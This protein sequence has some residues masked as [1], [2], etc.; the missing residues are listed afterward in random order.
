MG[1]LRV[2]GHGIDLGDA[3]RGRVEERMAGTIA[4]YLDTHM[5]DT[6]S[7]HVTLRRDGTAY[8]TD[9]VLHLVS[10]LTI[11]ASSAAHDPRASFEQTADRLEKRLRRYKHKL[12]D[13]GAAEHNGATVEAAYAVFAAPVHDDEEEDDD[14]EAEGEAHPPVVAE[15]TKTLQRRSVSEA[16]TALDLTGAPVIVFVHA[17]TGRINVVYRRSDGAIGWVDPLAAGA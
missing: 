4:K 17:G 14:G 12:K 3:L 15:S 8:R 2:T 6:C 10:G 13:H 5:S 9:C 1:G 16:V 11:E 7:G